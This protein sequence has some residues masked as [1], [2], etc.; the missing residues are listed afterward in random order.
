MWNEI[1]AWQETLKERPDLSTKTTALYTQDARRFATWL[2][3]EHSGLKA[4]EATPTDAKTHRDHL[5]A[6]RYA[7][8]TINRALIS[9]MLFFDTIEGTNPFRHLTM[10]DI[11]EP[12]PVALSK[13]EWNAV[14]RCAETAARRDH[15]LAL[16]LSTLFRYAGPRVS[17]V[18]ALQTPDV[19]ISVRRG[20][21]V[22]RRG[23][24]LKHREIP[25]VQEAR[26][27]FC[28]N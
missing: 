19:Q 24:G 25:L 20:L 26:E 17:E 15:G 21:L 28:Q 16:A 22:I 2:Q 7:P 4:T 10:I 23:K 3:Q 12:A 1:A 8:T 9:L 14:R 11:V 27:R 18:A 5:L 6:K 13:T